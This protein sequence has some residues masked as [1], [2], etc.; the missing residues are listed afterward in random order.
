MVFNIDAN[1]ENADWT[2]QS[3]DLPPYK[4][5]EFMALI[6]HSGMSLEQ[7]CKLPVYKQAVL[8]GIIE[9]G[10]WVGD[11]GGVEMN[12]MRF[13][14]NDL[15]LL[16]GKLLD[17]LFECAYYWPNE[18]EIN[19]RDCLALLRDLDKNPELGDFMK[20]VESMF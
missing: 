7:F 10:R 6:K 16:T 12:S 20:L 18:D 11:D 2:K 5:S 17:L 3:W 1:P 4:S 13:N 8:K 14:K 9:D 19:E 15:P